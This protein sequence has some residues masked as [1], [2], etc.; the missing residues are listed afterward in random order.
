LR[1][2][3]LSFHIDLLIMD[4][5]RSKKILALFDVDGTLTKSRN[6]PFIIYCSWL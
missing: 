6:V 3:D 4:I 5:T 1:F 2:L